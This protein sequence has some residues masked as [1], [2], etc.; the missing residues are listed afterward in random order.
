MTYF[1]HVS[2]ICWRSPCTWLLVLCHSEFIYM[3]TLCLCDLIV[4]CASWSK[5]HGCLKASAFSFDRLSGIDIHT[6]LTLP[7]HSCKQFG[8]E[9]WKCFQLTGR[10]CCLYLHDV[11]LLKYLSDFKVCTS[12][13]HAH[14]HW[15]MHAAQ[16]PITLWWDYSKRN[17]PVICLLCRKTPQL[18]PNW[19]IWFN[20]IEN[21]HEA[22]YAHHSWLVHLTGCQITTGS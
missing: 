16:L 20:S 9:I 6:A 11:E 22:S 8:L 15:V 3:H 21:S 19:L 10:R 4:K 5:C 12:L 17:N 13:S 7:R 1:P 14:I 18:N 2:R